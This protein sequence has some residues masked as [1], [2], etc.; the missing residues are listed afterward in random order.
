MIQGEGADPE[1][2][3]PEQS[4]RAQWLN[5]WPV[6][7][8]EQSDAVQDLLSAGL[9][10]SL[11]EPDL[12]GGGPVF[13]AIED[14]HGLG[15]AVACVAVL[16]D[17]R[18]E[19]DGWLREDWDSAI[20]DLERLAESREIRELHVGASLLDRLPVGGM[21]PTA[22]PAVAAQAR[23]GLALL[24][25]LAASGRVVHDQ[26]TG[27]LDAAFRVAQVRETLTGLQL[28][29]RGPT[30]LVKAAAW[31]L[32]AAHRPARIPAIH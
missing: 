25:D 21:L 14:D 1:E 20:C 7:K 6:R 26:T 23:P 10:A 17:G 24:R 31:A 15:A 32:Q 9:W 3:D 4:F 13:V 18:F 8:V 19:L 29:P 27:E 22:S 2:P 11:T 12:N 16:H 30:H 28:V 5:Q